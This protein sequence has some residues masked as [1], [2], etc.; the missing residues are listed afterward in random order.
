[1]PEVG[2]QNSETTRNLSETTAPPVSHSPRFFA[3]IEIIEALLLALVAV[4][5]AWSGY[6]SAAWGS[7]RLKLYGES[8]KLRITAERLSTLGDQERIYDS[9]TFTAW[10]TAAMH[11]DKKLAQF[12]ERR[13]RDEQRKAFA[14]WMKTDPFNNPQAPPGPGLMPEYHIAKSEEA[15]KLEQQASATFN[16]GTDAATIGDR[17]VRATVLLA[18]VLLFT[19]IGQKFRMI[20]VRIALLVFAIVVLIIPLASLWSLPRL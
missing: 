13:F 14:A 19:A 1:M 6:Q 7:Q 5:T 12:F 2:R 16:K 10:L 9:L 8:S 15:A 3:G 17:Y 11:G 4:A 20:S 18:M